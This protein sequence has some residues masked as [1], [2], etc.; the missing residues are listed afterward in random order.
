[1]SEVAVSHGA[2][3]MRRLSLWTLPAGL[4]LGLFLQSYENA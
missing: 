1:M 3:R 4:V 2:A